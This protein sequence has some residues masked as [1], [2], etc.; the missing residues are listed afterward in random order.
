[1][2]NLASLIDASPVLAGSAAAAML[3]TVLRKQSHNRPPVL[4]NDFDPLV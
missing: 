2:D 4:G 1:M 3:L